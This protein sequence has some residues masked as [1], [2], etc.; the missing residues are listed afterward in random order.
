MIRPAV[1]T[2]GRK[3]RLLGMR[4]T[5][6]Q[7]VRLAVRGPSALRSRTHLGFWYDRHRDK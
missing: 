4:G 6:R 3:F 5:F 1:I 2:S 7:W